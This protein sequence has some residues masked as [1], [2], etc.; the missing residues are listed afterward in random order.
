MMTE[1]YGRELRSGTTV[2]DN[3]QGRQPGM[4]VGDGGV[5]ARLSSVGFVTQQPKSLNNKGYNGEHSATVHPRIYSFASAT[6]QLIR[7]C[8]NLSVG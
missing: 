3:S 8:I 4:I 5:K 2:E 6:S 1:E 7:S